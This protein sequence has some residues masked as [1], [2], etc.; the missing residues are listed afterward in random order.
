MRLSI[1]ILSMNST[2]SDEFAEFQRSVEESVLQLIRETNKAPKDLLNNWRAFSSAVNWNQSWIQAILIFHV[3]LFIVSIVTR[4]NQTFQTICFLVVMVILA[5]LETLNSLG[6]VHW[7][8]FSDQNYFDTRGV[9]AGVVV[10]LPLVTL[11]FLQL[12]CMYVKMYRYRS[13]STPY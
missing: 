10:A 3:V 4:N 12:V 13:L 11:G 2:Y 8:S 6:S 1:I 5:S 7:K 9:F